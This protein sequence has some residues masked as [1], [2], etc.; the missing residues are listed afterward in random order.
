MGTAYDFIYN[1]E[2]KKYYLVE[3]NYDIDADTANLVQVTQM[4]DNIATTMYKMEDIV[5][6][7]EKEIDI[8]RRNYDKKSK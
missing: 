2:D 3:V 5:Y 1:Q 6:N 8:E 4:A 7:R